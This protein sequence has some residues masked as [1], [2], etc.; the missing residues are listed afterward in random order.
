M[1]INKILYV[2]LSVALFAGCVKSDDNLNEERVSVGEAL[3]VFTVKGPDGATY[4]PSNSVGK[5]TLICFFNTTCPDC[6]RELPKI[7]YVWEQLES[8]GQF[9]LACIGRDRT[10]AEIAEYWTTGRFT[11]PYYE[12]PARSVYEL[13]ATLKIPRLYL[14]DKDGIVREI[15]IEEVSLTQEQLL[16]KIKS[17]TGTP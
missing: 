3:P 5:V 7:Q 15:W 10:L 8:E 4:S 9:A 1:K 11:M 16:A 6:H 13:F 17:Y 14:A 12:D 2:L